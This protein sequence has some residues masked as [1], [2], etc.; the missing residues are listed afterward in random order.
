MLTCTNEDF[1]TGIKA[2]L[3]KWES[4]SNITFD[5]IKADIIVKYNNICERLKKKNR[6][7]HGKIVFGEAAKVATTVDQDKA[8]IVALTTQLEEAKKQLVQAYATN[9]HSNNRFPNNLATSSG[10]NGCKPNVEAWQMRKT[11]GDKVKHDGKTYY[12]CPK[13]VYPGF[14]DGLYVTHPPDQHDQWKDRQD[15]FKKRG[16]YADS[17]NTGNQ[18]PG[19]SAPRAILNDKLQA[20]LMTSHGFSQLQLDQLMKEAEGSGN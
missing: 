5:K 19:S 1:T 16:K 20:V 18:Q 11:L 8:K 12:W 13:H 9:A 6:T 17:A 14:Y 3:T 7:F 2:E 15:R 4:G 10:T